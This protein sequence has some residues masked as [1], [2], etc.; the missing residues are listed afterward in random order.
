VFD[1][2]IQLLTMDSQ[3]LRATRLVTPRSREPGDFVRIPVRSDGELH[4]GEVHLW[5]VT[6]VEEGGALL[7][8][9]HSDP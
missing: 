8:L 2:R 5:R 3:R 1:Y 6:R 7:V 9:V 4:P